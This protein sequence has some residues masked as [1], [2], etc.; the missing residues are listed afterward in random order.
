MSSDHLGVSEHKQMCF[1]STD[2]SVSHW[3]YLCWSLLS[4]VPVSRSEPDMLA[5]CGFDDPLLEAN[6][7]WMRTAF[8]LVCRC[9]L[10]QILTEKTSTEP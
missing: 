10:Q 3:G 4:I 5:G 9:S 8:C 7:K 1:H 2:I 6:V